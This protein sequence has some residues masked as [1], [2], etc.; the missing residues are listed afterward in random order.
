MGE[1]WSSEVQGAGG[2][3]S[4][5]E[6]IRER[7]EGSG[8]GME[9]S[10]DGGVWLGKEEDGGCSSGEGMVGSGFADELMEG[11]VERIRLSRK[12]KRGKESIWTG[13]SKGQSGEQVAMIKRPAQVTVGGAATATGE[14]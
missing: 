10:G 5:W 9:E 12:Q 2:K 6:C 8:R 13:E 3:E 1:E 4:D 7:G 14:G 11:P